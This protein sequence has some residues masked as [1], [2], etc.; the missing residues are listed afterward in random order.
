MRGKAEGVESLFSTSDRTAIF[1]NKVT[2][3]MCEYLIF[4]NL[5]LQQLPEHAAMQ[6]SIPLTP[7]ED[8]VQSLEICHLN[9]SLQQ[10]LGSDQ[11]RLERRK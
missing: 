2:G 4:N 11:S 8:P 10:P 9:Y 7:F 3:V 5:E 1:F 6:E